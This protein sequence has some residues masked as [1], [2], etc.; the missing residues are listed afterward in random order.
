M[1]LTVKYFSF[2]LIYFLSFKR[3]NI[4]HLLPSPFSFCP[5]CPLFCYSLPFSLHVRSRPFQFQIFQRLPMHYFAV[6]KKSG[7]ILL[8][9]YCSLLFLGRQ[10][11]CKL[12]L[13]REQRLWCTLLHLICSTIIPSRFSGYS[14]PKPW[15]LVSSLV[16]FPT[17][18]R[19]ESIHC[20]FLFCCYSILVI[21]SLIAF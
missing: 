9:L 21:G 6:S 13:L 8:Y 4:K 2:L 14:M 3:T 12:L 19:A 11:R 17:F 1:P 15:H 7:Y 5:C 16:H 18:K 20:H 10:Q